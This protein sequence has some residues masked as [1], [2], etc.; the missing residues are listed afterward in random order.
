MGAKRDRPVVPVVAATTR[1][2]TTSILRI[3]PVTDRIAVV[4]ATTVIAAVVAADDAAAADV[5]A[6]LQSDVAS[7]TY[8]V[9][10]CFG[11]FV[12]LLV[13]V[14]GFVLCYRRRRR[15]NCR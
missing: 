10:A 3:P 2:A 12:L 1:S 15:D 13:S 14:V 4:I 6:E 9:G 5:I 8:I 7:I 11:V